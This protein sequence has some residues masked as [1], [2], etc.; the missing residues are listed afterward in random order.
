[1]ACVQYC[2]RCGV[3]LL[4]DARFCPCCGAAVV[5]IENDPPRSYSGSGGP[6]G[7]YA[8]PTVS[9]AP[10]AAPTREPRGKKRWLPVAALVAL[11]LLPV[12]LGMVLRMSGTKVLASDVE[13]AWKQ[14][15]RELQPGRSAR[16]SGKDRPLRKGLVLVNDTVTMRIDENDDNI[17]Y[18]EGEIRNDSEKMYGAVVLYFGVYDWM[19]KQLATSMAVLTL[20]S[21]ETGKFSARVDAPY[22]QMKNYA[23]GD[24]MA[25][26]V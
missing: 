19:D 26:A 6:H 13:P 14:R 22:N 16:Y 11:L 21:G 18:L 12:V 24:V 20:D 7:R 4:Q 5:E 10:L 2:S 3:K 15:Q 8:A 9:S 23:L 25:M 17:F 1:M